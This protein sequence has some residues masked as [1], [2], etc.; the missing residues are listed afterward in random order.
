MREMI[1]NPERGETKGDGAV[2]AKE[3]TR[4]LRLLAGFAHDERRFADKCAMI[5]A[6][7]W[8]EHR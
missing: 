1:D 4:R 5:E 6:A 7:E 3:L 8:I 2:D